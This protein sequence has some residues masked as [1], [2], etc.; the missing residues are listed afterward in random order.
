M[1]A[2]G[3]YRRL[4]LLYPR[5]MRELYSTEMLLVFSELRREHGVRVWPRL[6]LDLAVSVPRTRLESVMSIS[7]STRAV[8]YTV[9]GAGTLVSLFTLMLVGPVGLPVPLLVAA[10]ALT[11]RSRLARSLDAVP[12]GGGVRTALVGLV[13]SGVLLVAAIG[14]WL[15]HIRT[16][17]SLGDTTVV[18]HNVLGFSALLGLVAFSAL[19][20][21]RVRRGPAGVGAEG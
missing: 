14:S 19:L 7:V 17:E 20:V 2:I 3:A 21:V 16:Y 18:A 13:L 8:T 5:P 11:Q 12:P 9:V 1:S 10:V 4:L 15:Y 6:L